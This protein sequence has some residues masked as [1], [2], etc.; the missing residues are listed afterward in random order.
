MRESASSRHLAE[1]R[2]QRRLDAVER[3]W[4]R[5]ASAFPRALQF[6]IVG[7]EMIDPLFRLRQRGFGF[8][9]RGWLAL[10]LSA[11]AIPVSLLFGKYRPQG[12]YLQSAEAPRPLGVV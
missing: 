4:F 8:L 7:F 12:K 9:Q 5:C 1:Y 3:L 11:S 6:G 10:T 2:D